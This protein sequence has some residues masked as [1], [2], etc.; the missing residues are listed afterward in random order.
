MLDGSTV[1]S[2]SLLAADVNGS[3]IVT[4]EGLSTGVHD[5]HPV[6][7]A[8]VA[9]QGLQCG[10]CTPGMVLSTIQ[11]LRDNPDPT[12]EEV[13]HGISGNLCRCTGYEFIVKS[14]LAAAKALRDPSPTSV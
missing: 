5:L 12:P 1:K 8:F 7:Q 10:F 2:C 11:L 14:I 13:R 6:Q 4:V 3:E 9:N